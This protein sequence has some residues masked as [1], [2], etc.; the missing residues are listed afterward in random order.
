MQFLVRPRSNNFLYE[1]RILLDRPDYSINTLLCHSVFS[2]D[3]ILTTKLAYDFVSDV[4][5]LRYRQISSLPQPSAP[6]NRNWIHI[7][8]L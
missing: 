6:A 4:Y 1:P 2:G 5:L 7:F 3:L 8:D